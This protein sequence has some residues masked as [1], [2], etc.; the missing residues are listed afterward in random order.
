MA[1]GEDQSG[2][3]TLELADLHGDIFS[4]VPSTA[5]DWSASYTWTGTQEFGTTDGTPQR[6]DYLG[7]TERQRDTNSNLQLMGMRVYNPATGRFMQTDPV[8][9]G[10]S[11]SYDYVSAD[12][13]DRTD[14]S[15]RCEFYWWNPSCSY[16]SYLGLIGI[17]FSYAY[18]TFYWLVSYFDLKNPGR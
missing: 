7:A 17:S 4:T 13:I 2:A 11:N 15:G 3:V 5:T 14:L 9:G 1:G 10:S 12:P 16:T 18:N 8:S 6:Y